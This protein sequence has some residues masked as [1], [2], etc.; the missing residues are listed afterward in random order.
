MFDR[1]L[2]LENQ[3]NIDK[4]LYFIL[5]FCFV[6]ITFILRICSDHD[7]VGMKPVWYLPLYCVLIIVESSIN[8]QY[9]KS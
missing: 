4:T 9:E 1:V 7:L 8:W 6:T 2:S 3:Q 5:I